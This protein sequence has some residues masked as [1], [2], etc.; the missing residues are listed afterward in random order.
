ML[1]HLTRCQAGRARLGGSKLFRGVAV[2]ALALG[3]IAGAPPSASAERGDRGDYGRGDGDVYS[4][5]D[6]NKLLSFDAESPGRIKSRKQ[7]TGTGDLIGIDVRP[8]NG[9]LYSVDRQGGVYTIDPATGAAT[10]TGTLTVPLAGNRFGFDFNPVVDRLRIVS[11]QDQNLRVNV[12]GGATT[13]DAALNYPA[14]DR[15]AGRNP[16]VAGVAYSN[17]DTDPNTGTVLYDVDSG[18]DILARQDPPNNGTLNTIGALGVDSADL[19]GFDIGRSGGSYG[20]G[21]Y[22]R[23]RGG[24]SGY[25]ALAALQVNGSAR[26]YSVDL[27]S[28]RVRD[29]GRIGDGEKIDGLAISLQMDRDRDGDRPSGGGRGR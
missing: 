13:A 27:N 8:A 7:I 1:S 20:D 21:S 28:G 3:V 12:D 6:D 18:L 23:S 2:G 29:R 22:G 17:P 10:R 24:D 15:N 4:L 9:M 25:G 26:L 14:G 11:D 5:T 19:V 16:N